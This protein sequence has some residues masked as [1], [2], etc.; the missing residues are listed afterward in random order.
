MWMIYLPDI[1]ET[2]YLKS[3]IVRCRYTLE[4]DDEEYWIYFQGP[5][6]TDLRWYIKQG[7]NFNELNLSGTIFIKNTPK[8]KAFFKRF[9]KIQS[10]EHSFWTINLY[11]EL[12]RTYFVVYHRLRWYC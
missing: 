10:K 2:A 8:T 7:V 1:T 3:Q 5:T 11:C 4:I 12:C 9:T 6:E